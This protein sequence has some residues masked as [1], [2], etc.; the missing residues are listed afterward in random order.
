MVGEKVK[1]SRSLSIYLDVMRIVAAMGVVFLHARLWIMPGMP[2][3]V[4]NHGKEAV[5]VFFVLSGFVI[6]YVSDTKEGDARLYSVARLSRI[7]S[8]VVI[9]IVFCLCID[10]IGMNINPRYYENVAARGFYGEVNLANILQYLTLTH[11]LWFN[12]AQ[13]GTMQPYWSLGYEVP[14]YLLFG[15]VLFLPGRMRSVG[16]ALWFCL[17]GPK[18]AL[19]GVIWML[20]AM[21]Y[22]AIPWFRQ[23]V[24]PWLAKAL[25]ATTF[26]IYVVM[27]HFWG[28][29]AVVPILAHGSLRAEAVAFA[30][31]L[32]IGCV[33]SL[34]ILLFDCALHGRDIWNDRLTRAIRWFAGATFTIYIVHQPIVIFIRGTFPRVVAS[35]L[36]GIAAIAATLALCL[37]VAEL[38][39]RRKSIYVAL[40]GKLLGARSPE[41]RPVSS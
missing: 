31:A 2:H 33:M 11:E 36:Y 34:N 32:G 12:Q 6:K 19:Y 10:G 9:S 18:I 25:F 23:K 40:F 21:T 38:G 39:E 15:L 3:F 27:N 4:S 41:P 14:Y 24:D 37:V 8:V 22:D 7:Y 20:G 30:Y 1:L 5:I 26:L 28:P 17:V 13:L 29:H 35:P 16:A